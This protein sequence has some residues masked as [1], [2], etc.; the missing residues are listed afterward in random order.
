MFSAALLFGVGVWAQETKTYKETFNVGDETVLELNTSHADIEFETWDKNQVEIV[1]TITLDGADD[2]DAKDYFKKD[3]IKIVGN[4]KEIEVST[5][6]RNSWDFALAGPDFNFDMEPLFLDLEIP[7]LPELAV[8]PELAVMPPM[9][10]LNFKSF[11]YGKYK[12]EGSKYLEE[13]AESFA[14]GFDEEYEE[15]MKEWSE[16]VEE[17]ANAWE[18]RNAKRLEEREK[19]LEERA[20]ELEERAE[21]RA[22]RMEERAQE[23]EDRRMARVKTRGGDAHRLFYSGDDEDGPNIFFLSRDGENKKYKVKK[24][25][26]IKMPKSVKLKLNVKHGEV[27]LASTT[28]NINASLRYASLLASTIEGKN[29]DIRA[30]Y[31][32]IVVQNWSVGQLKADYSERIS[33]KE[34]GELRLNA[35]SSNIVIDRLR[36]R[37]FVTN[38]L[39]KIAINHI[40]EG[41]SDVDVN[42]QNG[43]VFCKIPS[44][45]V[46]FYL[47]G[48]RSSINYPAGLTMERNKN[49]DNVV[50]KGYKGRDNSGKLITINSKYSEVVLEN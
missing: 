38:N 34:V 46:S 33:L 12:E 45:P 6:G 11:D 23:A 20:K 15:K 30:S 29:T 22:K 24:T 41:F 10:P 47:N 26:K 1:A 44:T 50:H 40:N 14:D 5:V 37:V 32:P 8:I 2:E 43:E 39:G 35:N 7:D 42:V 4:S 21:E 49:F 28:K 17:R 3:P 31:S 9:P 18:E 19:R 13:W 27:K 36:D 16:R 48:T 25:I